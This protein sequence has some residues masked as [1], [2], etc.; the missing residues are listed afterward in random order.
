MI[1]S[2]VLHSV[3]FPAASGPLEAVGNILLRLKSE[4]YLR[5]LVTRSTPSEALS[6]FNNMEL[7]EAK[8]WPFD[9]DPFISS[10]IR[11]FAEI[12]GQSLSIDISQTKSE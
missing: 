8:S 2:E 12:D 11:I 5:K 7:R 1:L 4:G 6:I 10:K 9:H 3:T